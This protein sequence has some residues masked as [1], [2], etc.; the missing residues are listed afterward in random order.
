MNT[1]LIDTSSNQVIKVG[2]RIDGKEDII[3]QKIDRQK[4]QIVLPLIDKLTK[5]HKLALSDIKSIEVNT[6]P[7]SFTGIRVG[8]AIANALGFTL[9]VPVNG[10]EIGAFVT[11]VY[12]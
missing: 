9:K 4:A 5:K 6:G 1:L 2:L 10:G 7:G 3:E 12:E 11:P 8:I